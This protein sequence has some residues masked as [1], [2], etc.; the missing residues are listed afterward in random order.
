M[1]TQPLDLAATLEIKDTMAVIGW[2]AKGVRLPFEPDG[3][4]RD[5]DHLPGRPDWLVL[6]T[7]GHSDDST[8]L[9][10]APRGRCCQATACSR[11]KGGRGS[12]PSTSTA[13][14]RWRPRRACEPSTSST[15]SRATASWC[16]GHG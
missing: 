10:H 1:A 14:V 11:S 13:A 2:D 4:L 8:C 9:L 16:R 15:C 7:P 5:G 3:W 12:T 6:S